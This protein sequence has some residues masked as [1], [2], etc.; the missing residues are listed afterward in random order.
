MLWLAAERDQPLPR[1]PVQTKPQETDP[2][3]YEDPEE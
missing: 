3:S 2:F 1:M